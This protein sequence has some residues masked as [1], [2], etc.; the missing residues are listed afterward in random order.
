MKVRHIAITFAILA[1]SA[2]GSPSQQ[3]SNEKVTEYLATLSKQEAKRYSIGE[4]FSG[5][6]RAIP[7]EMESQL[8]TVFPKHSFLLAG[9]NV[10]IDLNLYKPGLLIAVDARSGHVVGHSWDPL[11]GNTSDGFKELLS[12]YVADSPT[13]AVRRAKLLFELMAYPNHRAENISI[14]G[15]RIKATLSTADAKGRWGPW[16]TITVDIDQHFRFGRMRVF[17]AIMGTEITD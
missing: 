3:A 8:L 13:D 5:E 4:E 16:R 2:S 12:N 15:H 6:F 10:W 1:F 14:H 11:F 17:N 9:M 7:K